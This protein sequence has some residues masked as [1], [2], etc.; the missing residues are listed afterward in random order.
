MGECLRGNGIG[1]GWWLGV[2]QALTPGNS[3]TRKWVRIGS[4]YQK[5]GC[6]GDGLVRVWVTLGMGTVNQLQ[7]RPETKLGGRSGSIGWI[8]SKAKNDGSLQ[9][10][11]MAGLGPTSLLRHLSLQTAVLHYVTKEELET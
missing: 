1:C 9:L 5:G 7:L 2:Q 3:E 6:S 10:R 8:L 4:Q 11:G